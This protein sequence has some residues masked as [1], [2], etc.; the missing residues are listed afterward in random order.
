MDKHPLQAFAYG[1]NMVRTVKDEE[2]GEIWFIAK[3]VASTLSYSDTQAMT[4]RLDEDEL[5]SYT[6]NSSG[7]ARQVTLISE[8]GLYSAILG[9]NKEE[10]KPFK[11]WVTHEVLPSIRKTGGY[12]ASDGSI[13]LLVSM[14]DKMANA[15]ESMNER[16]KKVESERKE[17][18]TTVQTVKI[19][20]N[21]KPREGVRENPKQ[22]EEFL[23]AVVRLL[24][25]RPHG[26]IQSHILRDVYMNVGES[27]KVRW[28]REYLNIAW[29]IEVLPPCT[30]LYRL[31]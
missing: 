16:L 15:L 24:S 4:R 11:R 29:S 3:D 9:S 14:I 13:S 23:D 28:L 31:I 2:S 19:T 27:T 8:S 17:V 5:M 12:G 7:Q 18:T 25:E 22:K 10:A 20:S 21:F 6:D 1:D 26:V 30:Y